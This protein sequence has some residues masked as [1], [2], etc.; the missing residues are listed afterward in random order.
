MEGVIVP[1][2]TPFREDYSIDFE[3]LEWHIRFLEEKGV[4]GIFVN[5]TTGE[6]TSL[7]TDERKMLAE[8]GRE[9]TSGMYLVGTGSTSTLEVIELSRHA[10]D[11]GADGIVIVAPYYC[12]LKDEEILKHFSMVAERVDIPIIVYAIPSC[13]NPVPV[14][15]IRKV[16]L[17]YSNIIGVKASVDSLTYLQELIEVKE[18]RKDF[19]V[20]TG[21][22]QYFLS[23]LLLGGDGG[24][25]ACANFAPEIHLQIWNS[26]KRRNFEEAIKLSRVL[27]EISRIY[28]VAS[29]FASA[30]KLAMIA[31]GFPIKPVL[32]PPHV[33]DGE[34]VF[35]EIKGILRSLEN[36]KP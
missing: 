32:R 9:I 16:S 10:E 1:L 30:V 24:I 26:F 22:D 25:M 21:L 36:V 33:I 31:K 5:S 8:K 29:S 28:N 23:T 12:K 17:E 15:I 2:V 6:F 27:G 18:E 34:E 4:H 7:N 13:A 14:D 11:I 20:F 3:A 19:R 35:N